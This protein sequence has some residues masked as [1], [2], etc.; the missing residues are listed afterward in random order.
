[1]PFRCEDILTPEAATSLVGEPVTL[2]SPTSSE[3]SLTTIA[4]TYS[5]WLECDWDSDSEVMTGVSVYVLPGGAEEFAAREAE[6]SPAPTHGCSAYPGE[7]YCTDDV[8]AGDYWIYASVTRTV[9]TDSAQLEVE[10]S[11]LTARLSELASAAPSPA[12]PD[13]SDAS[14]WPL[15]GCEPVA[16]SAPV[17]MWVWNAA[18]LH[19]PAVTC[20]RSDGWSV[21][22]LPGGAWAMP[23]LVTSLPAPHR[24]AGYYEPIDI[25]TADAS[26]FSSGEAC[27]VLFTVDDWLFEAGVYPDLS[28]DGAREAAPGVVAELLGP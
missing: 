12:A 5:G 16:P 3:T 23:A 1:V 25:P 4:R 8:V 26:L 27:V 7:S 20:E 18:D 9:E 22:A 15:A 2:Q 19:T 6:G 28:C 24:H 17:I 10:W 11:A 13:W 14:T 21:T